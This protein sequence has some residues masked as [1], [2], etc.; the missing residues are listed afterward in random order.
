MLVGDKSHESRFGSEL[1]ALQDSVGQGALN[2][3]LKQQN[4]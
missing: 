3:P 2:F 1:T 4:F